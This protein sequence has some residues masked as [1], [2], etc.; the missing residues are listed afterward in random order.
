[1]NPGLSIFC[2]QEQVELAN[3]ALHPHEIDEEIVDGIGRLLI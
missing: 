3:S 1:M 2:T